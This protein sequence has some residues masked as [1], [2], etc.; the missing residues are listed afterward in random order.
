MLKV[1]A[2]QLAH[3]R[4][5]ADRDGRGRQQQSKLCKQHECHGCQS[6]RHA[7]TILLSVNLAESSPCSTP[8][9]FRPLWPAR[10]VCFVS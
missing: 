2:G 9:H 4:D 6:R 8:R 3:G 7:A 5:G 1:H 10:I